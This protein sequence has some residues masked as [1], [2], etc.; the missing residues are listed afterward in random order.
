MAEKEFT[1]I[2]AEQ[3]GDK[4]LS[5]GA[6]VNPNAKD[7]TSV[8]DL[9][10]KTLN[11]LGPDDC[12]KSLTI[13]GHGH[14]GYIGVGAGKT[15]DRPAGQKSISLEN[16]AQWEP[17]IRRLFCR[18]CDDGELILWGC[19][20]GG[21]MRGARLLRLLRNFIVCV[22]AKAPVGP[23]L[24]WV[25]DTAVQVAERG[26]VG[27]PQEI[28]AELP[29]TKASNKLSVIPAGKNW[30]EIKPINLDEI[31]A[32]RFFHGSAKANEKPAL[33]LSKAAVRSLRQE[34]RNPMTFSAPLELYLMEGV[35]QFGVVDAQ[36]K[37]K[38]LPGGAVLGGGRF[39]SPVRDDYSLVFVLPSAVSRALAKVVFEPG[40]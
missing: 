6:N 25:Y 37:T 5:A 30:T 36:G 28:P 1:F 13:I 22:R 20:I 34:W 38:W 26:S 27:L 35:L 31:V 23:V 3:A 39:Y 7:A 18:F 33:Q 40:K 32:A 21:D 8:R 29:P 11:N 15:K 2:D 12:I 10:N 16:I 17:Q 19:A 9:V 14:Q 4:A 24:P